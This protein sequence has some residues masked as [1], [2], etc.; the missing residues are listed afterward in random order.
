MWRRIVAI[1]V[2]IVAIAVAAWLVLRPQKAVA[3]TVQSV[4]AAQP[5]LSGDVYPLYSGVDWNT[6]ATET[7]SIGSTTY[8]GTSVTSKSVT[9]TMNPASI[10]TPF[11]TYYNQKLKALGYTVDNMLAA[12]GHVGGQSAYRKGNELILTRFSIVYHT[13][14]ANAPS[15]CP[16]DVTLS[17]FSESE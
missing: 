3:P 12:G 8:S 5:A 11:D 7:F 16:C 17:L 15:E 6:P 4:P 2:I 1:L 13:V 10:F 14:P 9:N